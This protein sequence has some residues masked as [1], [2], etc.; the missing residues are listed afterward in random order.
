MAETVQVTNRTNAIRSWVS[1]RGRLSLPLGQSEQ[2]KAHVNEVRKQYKDREDGLETLIESGAVVVNESTERLGEALND[3]QAS[4]E[5]SAQ[6]TQQAADTAQDTAQATQAASEAMAGSSNRL[7]AP[8]PADFGVDLDASEDQANYN[9][10]YSYATDGLGL[11]YSSKPKKGE[12][13][14]HVFE[15]LNDLASTE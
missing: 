10:W 5:A 2:D 4:S 3:A 8:N 7:D 1:D 11:D 13:M 15:R 6:A 9:N 14:Q 12:L